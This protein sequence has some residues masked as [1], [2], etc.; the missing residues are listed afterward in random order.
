MKHECKL[1][2]GRIPDWRIEQWPNVLTC[3][4]ACSKG[5]HRRNMRN[6]KRAQ[7]A[8][9][10]RAAAGHARAAE[11]ASLEPAGQPQHP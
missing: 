1:C 2:G 9:Q 6:A 10:V 3:S 8:E 11:T 4:K 5:H 7:R